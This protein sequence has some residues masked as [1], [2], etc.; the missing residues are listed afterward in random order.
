MMSVIIQKEVE[1]N[2]DLDQI[3]EGTPRYTWNATWT[4]GGS[5]WV[6]ATETSPNIWEFEVEDWTTGSA[7][8]T[9]EVTYEVNHWQ[10]ATYPN[11]PGLSKSFTITQHAEANS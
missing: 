9:R 4:S 2:G 6:T 5:N 10:A 1:F 11:D 7:G 3:P 8:A